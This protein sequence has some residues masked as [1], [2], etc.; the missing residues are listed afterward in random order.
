MN[1]LQAQTS[2]VNVTIDG[3]GV[4]DEYMTLNTDGSKQLKLKAVPSKFLGDVTFDGWS[5]DATGTTEELTVDADKAQ[6]IHATFT[7][8]RPVKKYPLLNLKQSWADMGKPLY[9]EVPTVWETEDD[10]P[11]RG[12]NWLPVDYNRDGYIDI[13]QFPHRGMQGLDNHRDNVRFWLGQSNGLFD[14]DPKNDNRMAGMVLSTVMKYADLNDDGYPDICSFRTGYDLAGSTGDY[15]IILMSGPDGVYTDLRFTDYAHG[16]F[17]GGTPGDFDNDG[18][19][20]VLFWD[21]WKYDEGPAM[22]SLYLENDGKGNLIQRNAKEIIDLSPW[23]DIPDH[24]NTG[25]DIEVID[26][27]NDGYNDMIIGGHDHLSKY[28]LPAKDAYKCMPIVLWGD[29]SGKFLFSRS[30]MLPEPR[31]GYGITS[32]FCFYDFNGDGVK[33]IIVHK[34]GDGIWGDTGFY[35]E[36]YLQVCELDGDHYIDKT[37]KYIP[38][39]NDVFNKEMGERRMSIENIEGT[40]YLVSSETL[41][42]YAI[43]NGILE[44]LNTKP[45]T[46]IASYD[47]GL[48]L[49]ADGPVLTDYYNVGD[50]V[51]PIDSM[52]E[53]YWAKIADDATPISNMWRINMHHRNDTHFGRTCIR[54][55]RDG[56]DPSKTLERQHISFGFASEVDIKKLADEGY[57]LEFY[58]KNTDPD[59]TLNI[60]FEWHSPDYRSDSFKGLYT[61]VSNRNIEGGQF[62]GEWQRIQIPLSAF[63]GTGSMTGFLDFTIRAEKGNLNNEFF[64][65]D[66]RIRRVAE[67]S[68]GDYERAFIKDYLDRSYMAKERTAQVRSQEFKTMLKPLITRFAPD[69]IAYFDEHISDADVALTRNVA[70]GM[71]YYVAICLGVDTNNNTNMQ[72]EFPEDIWEYLWEPEVMQVLPHASDVPTEPIGPDD[73]FWLEWAEI[74]QA[75]MWNFCHMSPYSSLEV[76][77][78]DTKVNSYHWNNPFT[79]EEAVCAITRL[80]DSLDPE[81]LAS[82]INAT[83][84]T[85]IPMKN[86]YYNLN[87]QRVSYPGK[88]I[89]I[90]NGKKVVIK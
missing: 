42:P 17:H 43:R 9:Y 85:P 75:Y 74:M 5:G 45:P 83:K 69:S 80:Y 14:E 64:L 81:M 2:K 19:I 37:D 53:H 51:N 90:V 8:H 1:C 58:I 25:M 76:I 24:P 32:A 73:N 35:K 6:N 38:Q 55:N 10:F 30:T 84:M 33:E 49:Y 50:G 29:N 26:L 72:R 71:A 34:S 47:E 63:N 65:D 11:W 82:D 36:G 41:L 86:V 22:H 46:R 3:P 61:T 70:V 60:G 21:I 87:G 39:E 20:D 77:E 62:T 68:A 88:G 66:I 31:I 28:D 16:C 67:S 89:Y 23:I 4:V 79:W 7:Y 12:T 40:D 48:P 15:P 54:W 52:A 59:L 56:Q 27:N 57:H 13:V 18:D 78:M 44:P